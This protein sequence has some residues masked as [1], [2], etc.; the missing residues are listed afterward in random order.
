M[1]H[2]CVRCSTFYDD[3]AKEILEGCSCGSRMFF[4]V[5]KEKLDA[6]K[7]AAESIKLTD[8]DKKQIEDDIYDLIGSQIEH[9]LPVILDFESI[10]ILKPGQYEIDLVRLFKEEPL[11]FKLEDGKYMVDLAKSIRRKEK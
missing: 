10:R 5:K 11:V 4:F 3:G 7:K 9:D 6:V 2:Q 8:D 1:P